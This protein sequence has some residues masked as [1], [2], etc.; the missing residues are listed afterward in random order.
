[1]ATRR[2]KSNTEKRRALEELVHDLA[3]KLNAPQ[4]DRWHGMSTPALRR[5][6]A[7]QAADANRLY[8]EFMR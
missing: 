5:V 4:L 7:L 6:I 2:G 1:M 3:R 8:K